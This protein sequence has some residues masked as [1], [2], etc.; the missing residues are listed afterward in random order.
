MGEVSNQSKK[1][2]RLWLG[3]GVIVV[4]L[5]IVLFFSVKNINEQENFT[6]ENLPKDLNLEQ[7]VCAIITEIDG[8]KAKIAYGVEDEEKIR[9]QVIE[10]EI[11]LNI[12]LFSIK[13]PKLKNTKSDVIEISNLTTNDLANL[14]EGDLIYLYSKGNSYLKSGIKVGFAVKVDKSPIILDYD[15]GYKDFKAENDFREDKSMITAIKY[16]DAWL[17]FDSFDD[18]LGDRSMYLSADN[19]Y[20]YQ[21][22]TKINY[23]MSSVKDRTLGIVYLENIEILNM[24]NA[25]GALA[26]FESYDEAKGNCSFMIDGTSEKINI[27]NNMKKDDVEILKSEK[28]KK[29]DKVAIYRNLVGNLVKLFGPIDRD[30]KIFTGKIID[31]KSINRSKWTQYLWLQNTNGEKKRFIADERLL[32]KNYTLGKE[33]VVEFEYINGDY[34]VESKLLVKL[35]MENHLYRLLNIEDDRIE[36]GFNHFERDEN[37]DFEK[38]DR[39]WLNKSKDFRWFS[40]ETLEDAIGRS[41]GIK[42]DENNEITSMSS[43]NED[44]DEYIYYDGKS[45]LKMNE[46]EES[47]FM[48]GVSEGNSELVMDTRIKALYNRSFISNGILEMKYYVYNYDVDRVKSDIHQWNAVKAGRFDNVEGI[49]EFG[50]ERLNLKTGDMC[51][52][53]T[54]AKGGVLRDSNISKLIKLVPSEDSI[55]DGIVGLESFETIDGK[56]YK[57]RDD[58]KLIIEDKDIELERFF[59][60]YRAQVKAWPIVDYNGNV[61]CLVIQKDSITE[62]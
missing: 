58:V 25:F 35:N 14:K 21:N 10:K 13:D 9:K 57:F 34:V 56:N 8:D 33:D 52:V 59:E 17:F 62:I 22:G 37:S 7:L 16:D 3:L 11:D 27:S 29:G 39:L 12:P 60:D 1:N 4:A 44:S 41:V 47:P 43:K 55:F 2:V 24:E 36:I 30:R 19:F 53:S 28:L 32:E 49:E 6:I 15:S 20:K 26:E 50:L 42:L 46:T 54:N 48:L 40:D 18:Y 38:E 23:L 5:L 51:L 45:P 61:E 31:E